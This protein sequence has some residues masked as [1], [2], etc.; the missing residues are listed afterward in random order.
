MKKHYFCLFLSLI[1]ST[2]SWGQVAKTQVLS[3]SIKPVATGFEL[4]WPENSA[5][6][7]TYQFFYRELY[8]SD[9][10]WLSV[11]NPI[12]G[13]A[14]SLVFNTQ[15]NVEFAAQYLNQNNQAEAIGYIAAGVLNEPILKG[16]TILVIDSLISVEAQSQLA[17]LKNDLLASG[18]FFDELIVK[19]TDNPEAI[20]GKIQSLLAKGSFENNTVYIIGHVP[21][22]YSGYFS[23]TGTRPPPDGHVEG[24]GNHTGAWP[25]DV[26][27]ADFEG[28][29][30]DIL[31]KCTTGSQSRH[32]NIG[33][34]GKFDPSELPGKASVDL[35][36]VDFYDMPAFTESEIELT[37]E[38]LERTHKWKM[39]EIPYVKR[40]LIDNN[41][42]S[43]NL[44]STGYHN[45]SCLIQ[46]D[47]IFDNRDYFK[48][49]AL[50]NYLWSY[51]CGAGSYTSC[52]G[53]G[54]TNN[55]AQYKNKDSFNNIFTILAGSYF[56]D[57]DSKNNLLRASLAAGSLA[58]FWGG[59]P[60][61]YVHH[62]GLGKHIGY[63]ARISQNNSNEYFNG[64]FNA[65]YRGVHI[66]LIG[67]PTLTMIPVKPVKNVKATSQNGKVTLTWSPSPD[68]TQYEIY[69]I[70]TVNRTYI[71][72]N[73]SGD[74][75]TL[76]ADTFFVDECNWSSGDYIYGVLAA[77]GTTTPSGM[78]VN[79][80]LL[81]TAVVNHINDVVKKAFNE[82]IFYPNPTNSYLYI[83]NSN[84]K[85]GIWKV[86]DVSGRLVKTLTSSN[87][88]EGINLEGLENG[89]YLVSIS[90]NAGYQTDESWIIVSQ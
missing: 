45:F 22:P 71:P 64:N 79:R 88:S 68:A 12:Q 39:G 57:W 67:D 47:S 89:L 38:Y 58:T 21:V 66:A 20:K 37:K 77:T 75:Q 4:S 81:T 65:S 76:I 90:D 19:R 2:F 32:H 13:P 14:S 78:Y 3:L 9:P 85:S 82:M 43:L 25:A 8:G 6:T 53:I 42:G 35:G 50:G 51:G 61:W 73:T 84:I 5:R 49:Q 86:I 27:Y 46:K 87:L 18:W 15:K 56:G 28:I 62:M 63:G 69:R 41:F 1:T 10:S 80:S 55:F 30:E 44:A 72:V 34:D 23:S 52:N 11:G 33:G 74:C 60:K 40:A 7:G 70:D 54:N 16:R 17:T 31:V 26:F 29:W 83:R 48:S 59:I 24:S 36:R